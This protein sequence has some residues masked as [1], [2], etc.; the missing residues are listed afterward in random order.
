MVGYASCKPANA[1]VF[2]VFF[3]RLQISQQ[4]KNLGA[5]NF[6]CVLTYYPDRSSPILE[7]KGQGHQGQKMRLALRSPTRL[8][9][10]WYARAANGCCCGA[11]RRAHLLAGEGWHRR[12]RA[13]RLGT[14][15]A[16]STKAVW[17]DLR[18][19]NLLMHLFLCCYYFFKFSD[20]NFCNFWHRIQFISPHH[21][22]WHWRAVRSDA[23][24][25]CF[26]II[27]IRASSVY[28]NEPSCTVANLV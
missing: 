15:V 21:T 26:T 11:S 20:Y 3:V 10:E 9:Y 16:A 13:P 18:L 19:A 8:A 22:H 5:W 1:L 17:W 25:M 6:A 14:G 24:R 12:W 28:T 4:W 2:C 27:Q 23:S 7:I